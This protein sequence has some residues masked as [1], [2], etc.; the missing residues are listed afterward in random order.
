MT[1]TADRHVHT[2]LSF[3]G[4]DPHRAFIGKAGGLGLATIGF[5]EH[6]E[7]DERYSFGIHP[8]PADR[9]DQLRR[10][11]DEAD[12]G[13]IEVLFGLEVSYL[14]SLEG[15]IK[16]CLERSTF[17]DYYVGSV[18]IIELDGRVYD[19]SSPDDAKTLFQSFALS[20]IVE[21]YLRTTEKLAASG[22]FSVVGHIDMIKR[23]CPEGKLDALWDELEGGDVFASALRSALRNSMTLEINASGLRHRHKELYPREAIVRLWKENGGTTCNFGSD[24]HRVE[25]LGS[26]RAEVEA[27]LGRL[28]LS[29]V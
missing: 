5:C 13:G 22:L 23:Y 28:G 15:R 19:T 21:T 26:G 3:D 1:I 9:I 4:T 14:P 24:A 20:R 11:R 25:D 18:H 17:W 27:V 29:A 12:R 16:E 7:L 6:V 2:N 8:P 10:L